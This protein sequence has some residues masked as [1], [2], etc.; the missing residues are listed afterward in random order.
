MRG[1]AC[2]DIAMNIYCCVSRQKKKYANPRLSILG[3]VD[4]IVE[5]TERN[6]VLR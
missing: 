2:R 5:N 6:Q 3:Q 4:D 1:H